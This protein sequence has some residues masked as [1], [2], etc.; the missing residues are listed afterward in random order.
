MLDP[1][2]VTHTYDS[3]RGHRSVPGHRL[4]RSKGCTTRRQRVM[5]N[6]P[7]CW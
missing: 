6:A 1:V 3:A 7:G 5:R 4:I 2:F